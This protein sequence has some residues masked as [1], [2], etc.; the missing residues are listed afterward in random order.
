M[1]PFE[2]L[3]NKSFENTVGKDEILPVWRTFCHFYQIKN[4]CLQT[5]WVWKS[6][7]FV[8]WEKVKLAMVLLRVKKVRLIDI[9]PFYMLDW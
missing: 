6:L 5:L 8:V 3:Q 4:C 1:T 2:A 9:L 7:K